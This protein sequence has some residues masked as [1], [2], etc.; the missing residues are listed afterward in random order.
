LP[1]VYDVPSDL[2]IERVSEHLKL[3]VPEVDPPVWTPYVKTSSHL[4]EAPIQKDWWYTRCASLLR[5][6]YVRGPVGV[7]RLKKQYGGRKGKGSVG[8][9]K[10]PGGGVIIRKALHQLEKAGYV[11]TVEK[12][13]RVLSSQGKSLLDGLAYQVK[14]NLERNIPELKKYG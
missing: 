9:H 6:I 8:K 10:S 4:E 14:K 3:N 13:G 2:L 7:A 12:E 1:T 5:K 11:R